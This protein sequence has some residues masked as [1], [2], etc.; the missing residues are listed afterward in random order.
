MLYHTSLVFQIW[1]CL[2]DPIMRYR[3]WSHRVSK[4]E[5]FGSPPCI[6]MISFLCLFH[7][8]EKKIIF[9][10]LKF[11]V[12]VYLGIIKDVSFIQI[13]DGKPL[14]WT[15]WNPGEPNTISYDCVYLDTHLKVRYK[16]IFCL[17]FCI[18]TFAQARIAYGY[19]SWQLSRQMSIWMTIPAS[20]LYVHAGTRMKT[21]QD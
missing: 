8:C 4:W 12:N 2:N 14:S 15:N 13:H 11:Q 7:E 10:L 17:I 19:R 20:L 5:N 1:F 16:S 21:F 6:M 9:L 3:P 18:V